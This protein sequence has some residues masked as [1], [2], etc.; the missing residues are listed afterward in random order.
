MEEGGNTTVMGWVGIRYRMQV[1]E[2]AFGRE[3]KARCEAG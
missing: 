3:I 1:P 2:R